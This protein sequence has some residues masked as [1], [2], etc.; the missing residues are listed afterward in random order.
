MSWSGRVARHSNSS[1][2]AAKNT[3]VTAPANRLHPGV[4]RYFKETGLSPS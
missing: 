4:A 2:P 1:T 3:V